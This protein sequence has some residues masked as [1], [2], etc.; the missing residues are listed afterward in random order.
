[1]FNNAWLM[2]H[3]DP[4]PDEN[5]LNPISGMEMELDY[6]LKWSYYLIRFVFI[7]SLHTMSV[8]EQI[9]SIRCL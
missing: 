1:M 7:Q 9:M 2:T 8:V 6:L 5:E 3:D 4:N